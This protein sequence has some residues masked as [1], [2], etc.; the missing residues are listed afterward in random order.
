MGRLN[1]VRQH[2]LKVFIDDGI[3][4]TNP[5]YAGRV[6]GYFKSRSRFL[7]ME[8]R[9]EIVPGGEKAKDG[10]R[11]A[12]SMMDK[13]A[14]ARLCRQSFVLAVG[15]GSVLDIVGLAAALVHRGIRIIRI[16]ST[17]LAQDDAGVGV[18]NGIDKNGMK[19]YAGTFAPPFAV[20]NDYAL[21]HSLPQEYW[22]GGIAEAFKVAIIKDRDFFHYLYRHAALLRHRNEAAIEETIKRCAI[23]HLDH[24][25]SNGDPFEFGTARPLD[26]G[27]WSA[28][29]LEMLSH[30]ELNHGLAVSIGIALDTCYASLIKL[31]SV[32]ERDMILDAL[33]KTGLPTW[34]DLLELR[35]E[36]GTLQILRGLKDFQEHLGGD[37]HVTLPSRIG[38]KKEVHEMEPSLLLQAIAHLKQR[39]DD[40]KIRPSLIGNQHESPR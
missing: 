28:H 21:L 10:W 8:G 27:H 33:E 32:A 24:I 2:R 15:G 30:Y 11:V 3:I 17:V 36:D 19:N 9:A 40:L 14:E 18:K 22:L 16:P 35:A 5:G 31:I 4:E 26:F 1:E 29:R 37:L 12:Q 7:C 13:I 20:L 38:A 6:E 25:R 34:S 39:H 23:L